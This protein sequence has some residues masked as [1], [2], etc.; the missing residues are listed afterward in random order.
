MSSAS[1][2]L[3]G[4]VQKSKIRISVNGVPGV[5]KST[6]CEYL[7]RSLPP[8]LVKVYVEKGHLGGTLEAHLQDVPGTA[9]SFQ[10]WMLAQA[11]VLSDM[12]DV[13]SRDKNAGLWVVDR[14]Q[15][16]NAIFALMMS[17]IEGHIKPS[18]FALYCAAFRSGRHAG[19]ADYSIFLHAPISTCIERILDRGHVGEIE[20]YKEGYFKHLLVMS[21]LATLSQLTDP[22]TQSKAIV[23]DW[24]K[25]HADRESSLSDFTAVLFDRLRRKF[26]IPERYVAVTLSRGE[27]TALERT[28]TVVY[29]LSECV[30][31]LAVF[32]AALDAGLM[33]DLVYTIDPSDDSGVVPTK[34]ILVVLPECVREFPFDGPFMLHFN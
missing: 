5:G 17:Q 11:R 4:L 23:L 29:D 22:E 8:E 28:P 9:E 21:L 34:E 13:D 27:K 6:L 10:M 12:M 31:E 25:V 3:I 15:V 32:D 24:S 19:V 2:E 16:G 30:S 14:D 1:S 20:K 7:R 18:A 33:E 26:S